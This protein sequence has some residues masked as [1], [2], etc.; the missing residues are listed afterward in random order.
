MN[1]PA[2]GKR[3]R[4]ALRPLVAV[5]ILVLLFIPVHLFN[6]QLFQWLNSLHS[7]VSDLFW[8][9]FT[10]TGDGL[11]LCIIIGAFVVK[12]PRVTALGLILI[13]TSSVLVHV[14]KGA[15][16]TSR[17]AEALG[18]IHVIGPLLRSGSFPSG[19]TASAMSAALAVW[20]G[21]R[22][23][24]VGWVA[25]VVGVLIALSRIFVGAHF[26][27]DVIGGAICAL[28]CY[29]LID[30]LVLPALESSIPDRP[31]LARRSFRIFLW[32][33]LA[34]SAFAIVI[35]GPFGAES[36]VVGVAVGIAVLA[37]VVTAYVSMRNCGEP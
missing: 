22:S 36:P 11:F 23:R 33:E 6:R 9:T 15:F 16:P 26:P 27:Q 18:T 34:M 32:L 3:G 19:H 25:M 29:V 30:A 5:V 10:T 20:Y 1:E 12:N 31:I 37:F 24:A 7:P 14:I 8:V 2:S 21:Y 35:W 28:A 17:P 4:I 13:V